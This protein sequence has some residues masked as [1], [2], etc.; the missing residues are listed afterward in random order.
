MTF[1]MSEPQRQQRERE[2]KNY[3]YSD[4]FFAIQHL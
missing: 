3:I 2:E 4:V 1:K